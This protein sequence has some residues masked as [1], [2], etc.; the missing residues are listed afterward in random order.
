MKKLHSLRAYLLERIP[1][2]K[3]NP[4]RLLTFIEDGSIE[5]H[6]GAHLSHQYR[7]PVRV[8]LTDHA[9]ELDT[10][11]IPLLQWLSRYQPDLV[12]E[13]A[14]SFQAELLDNQ[15]WDLAIDVTLTERVVALVDCDAGT[16]HVDHRQP[17]FEIDPCAAGNWQLYIRDVDDSEE[18]DLVAEWEQ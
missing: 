8:V 15:R 7:V 4:D 5:F 6:C 1:G 9:G 13:E 17:E 3:R 18:Y 11:I 12:P 16:I 2:L 10:V 14:V